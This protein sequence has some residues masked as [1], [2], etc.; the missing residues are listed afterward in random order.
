M[1]ILKW[2]EVGVVRIKCKWRNKII[3]LLDYWPSMRPGQGALWF[4]PCLSYNKTEKKKQLLYG[5]KYYFLVGWQPIQPTKVYSSPEHVSVYSVVT[6]GLFQCV[7]S[8]R[9]DRVDI[10]TGGGGGGE[11]TS[12]LQKLPVKTVWEVSSPIQ[13]WKDRVF[14]L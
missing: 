10:T 14:G 7:Q 11:E 3:L 12:P 8:W 13:S 6:G 2:D 5:L 4:F 9:Q 1:D